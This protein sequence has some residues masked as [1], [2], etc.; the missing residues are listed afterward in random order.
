MRKIMTGKNKL[1]LMI[2]IFA[3]TVASGTFAYAENSDVIVKQKTYKTKKTPYKKIEY[4]QYITDKGKKYQ[5]KD[6]RYKVTDKEP[7]LKT[8][9]KKITVR[10]KNKPKKTVVQNNVTYRL[11]NTII[12]RKNKEK[13]NG[14]VVNGY[15]VFDN[16]EE[17]LNAPDKHVF[18][19]NGATARCSKINMVMEKSS[20]WR[21][22]YIDYTFT[23]TSKD[24]YE[25]NGNQIDGNSSNPLK[26][27]DN[28][29]L[30]SIGADKK[31]YRIGNTYWKGK[32]RKKNGVYSRILRV[33]VQKKVPHYRVNYKGHSKGT[34][35]AT[36]T[37]VSTYKGKTKVKS[38]KYIYEI[39]ATAVYKEQIKRKS[40]PIP[41][42]LTMGIIV[43]SIV[44]A[45]VLFIIF[46]KPRIQKNKGTIKK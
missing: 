25:W 6:V 14:R 22:S 15:L 43:L 41:L 11:I 28:Q 40:K 44:I 17:A 42:M 36:I 20:S 13:Y 26:G 24:Y 32:A 12:Q 10:T 30:K 4:Q 45:G 9:V 29:I 19:A 18:T 31:S 46:L 23:S 39:T 21:S 16:K 2:L 5:L 33:E 27:Y 38:G 3:F 1:I 7:I 8:N 34:V 37:Y 35:V